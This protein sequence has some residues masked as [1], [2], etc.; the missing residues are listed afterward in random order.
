MKQEAAYVIV[1][2][3]IAIGISMTLWGGA[4]LWHFY[5]RKYV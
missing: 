4:Q 5:P 2:G 1:T 3:L